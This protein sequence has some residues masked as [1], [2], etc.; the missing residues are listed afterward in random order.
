MERQAGSCLRRTTTT[1]IFFL[2]SIFR[3]LQCVD[4]KSFCICC[5][6]SRL[7]LNSSFVSLSKLLLL[8]PYW[9]VGLYSILENTSFHTVTYG[10]SRGVGGPILLYM[11]MYVF[12]SCGIFLGPV[13][14][15]YCLTS[16]LCVHVCSE[17]SYLKIR[18]LEYECSVRTA[19]LAEYFYC[20]TLCFTIG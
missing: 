15:K 7:S 12:T 5:I 11:C 16:K 2:Y 14:R 9:V 3:K 13:L 17:A 20:R 10:T 18:D 4:E 1:E 6:P 8:P 19:L